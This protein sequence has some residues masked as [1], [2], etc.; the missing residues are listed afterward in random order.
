MTISIKQ[1]DPRANYRRVK[2]TAVKGTTP[3]QRLQASDMGSFTVYL[4]KNGGLPVLNAAVPVEIGSANAKGQFYIP[5][6]AS[7]VD[8]EGDIILT[9]TN[10]GGAN[11]MEPREINIDIVQAYF[12]TAITGVLSTTGFTTDR[13][14]VID[15]YWTDSLILA[16]T[17]T[18]KGQL[19]RV[20]GYTGSSKAI[21]LTAGF[22][23]TGSPVNGDIFELINR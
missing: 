19:K 23:F 4:S 18:L 10:A 13:T 20:G 6:L 12:A 17:G 9:V 1:S 7:D 16:H 8:T 14:E 3:S 5:L 22:S 15:G 21:A 11:I 2:F